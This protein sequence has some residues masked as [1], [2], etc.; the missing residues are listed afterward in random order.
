MKLF[1]SCISK[2]SFPYDPTSFKNPAIEKLWSEIEA[3]A[4]ERVQAEEFEDLTV[5]DRERQEQRAGKFLKELAGNFFEHFFR[6][7]F[8]ID[9]K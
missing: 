9:L 3:Q 8:N 6:I 5:P 1:S 2:L 4:L 7:F